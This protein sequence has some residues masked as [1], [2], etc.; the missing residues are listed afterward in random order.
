MKSALLAS[1]ALI[2]GLQAHALAAEPSYVGKWYV[3]SAAECQKRAQE[4]A[5]LVEY[6]R[7]EVLGPEIRCRIRSAAARGSKTELSLR[8]EGE[9]QASTQREVVEVLGDE[10]VVTHRGAGRL[11][12]DAYKRCA[13]KPTANKIPPRMSVGQCLEKGSKHLGQVW[14]TFVQPA[15]AGRDVGQV[16]ETASDRFFVRVRSGHRSVSR[17]R[18]SAYLP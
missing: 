18:Q 11:I 7:R 17:W 9:R 5:E 8:C 4:S 3:D 15:L 1:A 10:M 12:S 2:L 16:R 13:P 14:S 6:T